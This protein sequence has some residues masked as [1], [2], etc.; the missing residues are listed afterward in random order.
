M[1]PEEQRKM[2]MGVVE[3]RALEAFTDEGG[4]VWL[5]GEEV[6]LLAPDTDPVLRAASFSVA[7]TMCQDPNLKL[8][9]AIKAGQ[10]EITKKVRPN[11]T[12]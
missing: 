1:T 9:K 10:L 6:D 3:V 4:R 2:M 5:A 7:M 8:C 12:P 11:F